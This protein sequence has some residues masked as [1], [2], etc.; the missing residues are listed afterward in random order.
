MG[1]RV[2]VLSS[3]GR[4]ATEFWMG[5]ARMRWNKIRKKVKLSWLRGILM[6]CSGWLGIDFSP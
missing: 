5:W 6:E 2:L 4:G 1:K 3:E